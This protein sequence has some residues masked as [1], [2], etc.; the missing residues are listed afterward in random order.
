MMELEIANGQMIIGTPDCELIGN[1]TP[2]PDGY[3]IGIVYPLEGGL[4]ID[5]DHW[6]SFVEL[7]NKI[8]ILVKEKYNG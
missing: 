2:V 1:I 4:M 7:V 3:L 5:G 6:S 8:D